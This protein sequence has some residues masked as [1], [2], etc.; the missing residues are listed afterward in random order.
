MPSTIGGMRSLP[1]APEPG[2]LLPLPVVV[3]RRFFVA[4]VVRG[5]APAIVVPASI[6][7]AGIVPAEIVPA[8]IVQAS[9]LKMHCIHSHAEVAMPTKRPTPCQG[10]GPIGQRAEDEAGRRHEGDR[11]AEHDIL[12]SARQG[13]GSLSPAVRL[14]LNPQ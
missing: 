13:S 9:S 6:V 10:I 7:S 12:E 1:V 4:F 14:F 5:T 8:D 2:R 11:G 3:V